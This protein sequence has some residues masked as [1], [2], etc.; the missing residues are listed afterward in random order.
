MTNISEIVRDWKVVDGW[1]VSPGV[2][3]CAEGNCVKIGGWVTTADGVEIGDYVTINHGVEIDSRA[4]IGDYVRIGYTVA[5]G[6][7]TQIA[8]TVTIGNTVE[9]GDAVEIGYATD[10]SSYVKIAD[11][12][13][14]GYKVKIDEYARVGYEVTIGHGATYITT[15]GFA[16]YYY[17]GLSSLNG[18]AYIGAGCRWFTLAEAIKHWSNHEEDRSMTM[19]LMESAKAI[20]DMKGLK[21]G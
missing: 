18:T 3:W 16:D 7:E 2:D 10:V 15:L 21:Y 4:K 14:I 8:D 9:I 20:A 11:R 6:Y 17:K 5:I 1:S 19:C 13:D 12:V